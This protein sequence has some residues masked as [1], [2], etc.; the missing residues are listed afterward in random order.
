MV[1]FIKYIFIKHI[2]CR[3]MP[4]HYFDCTLQQIQ[5]HHRDPVSF[6]GSAN[7]TQLASSVG[8]RPNKGYS[9]SPCTLRAQYV[10]TLLY[11]A[12]NRTLAHYCSTP[13]LWFAPQTDVLWH[14]LDPYP[15]TCLSICKNM[16]CLFECVWMFV[17]VYKCVEVCLATFCAYSKR[18]SG[19]LL[20]VY[21]SDMCNTR[22]SCLYRES[23]S[24]WMNMQSHS[25]LRYRQ[26]ELHPWHRDLCKLRKHVSQTSKIF[27]K[28]QEKDMKNH[29]QQYKLNEH[30][31]KLFHTTAPL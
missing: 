6:P 4:V 30:S 23:C 1:S 25:L 11:N 12:T 8:G 13:P 29:H 24:R 21:T 20:L 7:S 10:W 16:I 14:G 15:S 18:H 17:L 9:L 31:I 2:K 5:N 3:P 22:S 26:S 27:K 19:I 28:V